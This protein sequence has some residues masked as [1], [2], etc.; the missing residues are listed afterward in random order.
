MNSSLLRNAR[1]HEWLHL[2]SHVWTIRK[3]VIIMFKTST[4][5]VSKLHGLFS[6]ISGPLQL[7][8]SYFAYIGYQLR[9]AKKIQTGNYYLQI[10]STI[11][12][13]ASVTSAASTSSTIVR[14]VRTYVRNSVQFSSSAVNTALNATVANPSVPLSS[15][16][17]QS[18]I[19]RQYTVHL[20][21]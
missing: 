2:F 20:V 8:L 6:Q 5:N 16:Q 3:L 19:L 18:M 11:N 13:P 17:D 21:I 14:V 15:R 10:S 7:H 12:L 1:V 4:S 9:H